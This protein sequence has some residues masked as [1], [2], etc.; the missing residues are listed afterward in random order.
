MLSGFQTSMQAA[1]NEFRAIWLFDLYD[2]PVETKEMRKEYI[3]F[4]KALLKQGFVMLQYS[5]YARSEQ[6]RKQWKLSEPM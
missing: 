4:H 3:S 6:A 1:T 5:V 2:L